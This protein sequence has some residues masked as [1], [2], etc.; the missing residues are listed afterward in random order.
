MNISYTNFKKEFPV[1]REGRY[2]FDKWFYFKRFWSGKLINIGIK[3]H[4]ITIDIRGN[5]KKDLLGE[6]Y[7]PPT[8]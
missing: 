2:C 8:T 1:V 5:W 7:K 6:N 4:Q 3:H